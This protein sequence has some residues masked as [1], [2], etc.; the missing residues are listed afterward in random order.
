MIDLDNFKAVNDAYGYPQ[1]DV[2]LREVARVLR[3]SS[4]YI[5]HLARCGGEEFAVILPGSDLE[6]THR[7]GER[8][9]EQIAQ[10]RISRLDGQGTLRVTASCGVA[11]ARGAAA[12]EKGLVTA[13][14]S[15]LQDAKRRGD[16]GRPDSGVREPRRPEPDGGAGGA[17][18]RHTPPSAPDGPTPPN[19][20]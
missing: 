3:G 9:R 7:H 14:D 5:H 10:L 2:V 17:L 19:A 4:R 6:A 11:S 12:D 16:D 15:A 13:A 20:R 1:G 8:I 18:R